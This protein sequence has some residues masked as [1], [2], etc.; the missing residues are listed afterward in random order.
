MTR[1]T[2]GLLVTFILGLILG[3]LATHVQPTE[4]LPR[5][6]VLAPGIPPWEPG[7][8]GQR[9]RQGLRELGYIEGQTITLEVRWA[10]NQPERYP[11][12]AMD[13]LRLPVEI[14]IAGDAAAALAAQ[15]ATR[16]I[17][18]VMAVSADPVR[19]GLVASLARPGGNITGL[20]I[21]VPDIT[22]KRLELLATAVPGLSRVALLMDTGIPSQ[23]AE[24][25]D[26]EAAARG[27]GVQLL[28]LEVRGP[29]E[30]VVAF[31]AA[32]QGHAQALM[33]AQ[34][35]L[36][37]T[38]E[39]WLAE[40]ALAG[41]LPTMSGEVGYA[42]AGGLM[43]YGPNLPESWHRAATYVDKILKGAKPAE[44]PVEQPM[45]FELV[46]NLKT[47][48]ALGLT[49]PPTLLFQATEVIR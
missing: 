9:F 39:A 31:Q 30:F 44:L 19:A 35:P 17:P 12:L 6:G 36:F 42:Q 47:A 21:M 34:S 49:I 46:I 13:L 16:T 18:I 15:H 14:I 5:I 1:R 45:T 22:G 23:P 11:D 24:L 33:M 28:P 8:G 4:K 20:S 25:H 7:R 3:P 29:D 43:N 41:R 10:E 26:H 37:A 38:Y 2:I 32:T 48:Q 40:L 27:L